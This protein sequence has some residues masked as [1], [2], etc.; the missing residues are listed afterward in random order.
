MVN[1]PCR[2]IGMT[3]ALFRREG[4]LGRN[5]QC[6]CAWERCRV[7]TGWWEWILL[8]LEETFNCYLYDV[9]LSLV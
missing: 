1:Y 4:T 5:G 6:F 8:K 3:D 9:S 2:K 7:T